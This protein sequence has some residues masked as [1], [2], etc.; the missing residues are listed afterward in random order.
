MNPIFRTVNLA[1]TVILR[2]PLHR[3]LSRNLLLITVIGRRSQRP[4]TVPVTYL[5]QGQEV[6]IVS[7]RTDRWW[8]NLR[9]GGPVALRLRGRTV[10]GRGHV[11]EAAAEVLPQLQDHLQRMPGLAALLKVER[12]DDGHLNPIDLQRAA[13][14]TVVVMVEC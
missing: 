8:R 10:T 14:R 6:R 3:V 12:S 1:L 13:E 9:G 11:V 4:Y 7:E 2:S 5:Q